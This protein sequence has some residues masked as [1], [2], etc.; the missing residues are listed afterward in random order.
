MTFH[1]AKL[2][3]RYLIGRSLFVKILGVVFDAV[4]PLGVKN[5]LDE[6]YENDGFTVWYFLLHLMNDIII[7]GHLF[8]FVLTL[9][10]GKL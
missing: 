10:S 1:Q 8:L 2:L 6:D 5:V 4:R 7:I 3:Q 9:N